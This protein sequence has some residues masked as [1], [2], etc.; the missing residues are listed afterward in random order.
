MVSSA[1]VLAT[2]ILLH[3]VDGQWTLYID[4]AASL[5]IVLLILWTT[6][7]LGTI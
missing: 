2:G 1:V 7:P 6:V 4:P 3:F 5:L